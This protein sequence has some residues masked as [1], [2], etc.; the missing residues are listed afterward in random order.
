MIMSKRS[1]TSPKRVF[2]MLQLYLAGLSL[3]KTS[4]RLPQL[5]KR[6]QIH[7]NW[8]QRYK[9]EKMFQTGCKPSEFIIDETLIKV[10]NDYYVCLWVAMEPTDE[11]LPSIRTSIERITLVAERFVQSLIGEDGKHHL[12][13]VEGTSNPQ[14][15]IFPNVE[16]H[17][18]HSSYQKSLME[19][20][21]QYIKDKTECFDGYFPLRKDKECKPKHFMDW[22]GLFVDMH[23]R[24][25]MEKIVK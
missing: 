15:C 3:R 14:A 12:T 16:H 25:V 8:I 21:I 13:T 23:N 10:G 11:T 5:I 19:R 1:R 4:Q 18:F 24:A 6:N 2:Y 9:S 17:H 20:T 7:S 22:L